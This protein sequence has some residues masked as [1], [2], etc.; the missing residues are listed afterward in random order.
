MNGS[1]L[2]KPLTCQSETPKILRE[3]RRRLWW[4]L[5]ALYRQIGSPVEVDLLLGVRFDE[6]KYL[7]EKFVGKLQYASP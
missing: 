4:W 5:E 6:V 3:I 2:G 7:A 1:E